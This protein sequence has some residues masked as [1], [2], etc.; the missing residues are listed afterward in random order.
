MIRLFLR[1]LR[2][3]DFETCKSCEILKQELAFA[4]HE[5]KELLDTLIQL[6]K[7]NITVPYQETKVLTQAPQVAGTFSRRKGLLEDQH[8]I[9]GEIIK[10]SPYIAKFD[11][12]PAREPVQHI[13]PASVEK[14]EKELGLV[15]EEGKEGNISAS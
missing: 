9:R 15:D 1:L 10:S 8:R 7:P 12:V 14:L 4:R 13:R 5:K 2:I 6:T 3:K 11:D